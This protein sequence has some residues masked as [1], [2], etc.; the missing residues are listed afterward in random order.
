MDQDRNEGMNAG[1]GTSEDTSRAEEHARSA[2]ENRDALEAQH[3]RTEATT[4]DE[5]ERPVQGLIGDGG[6]PRMDWTEPGARTPIDGGMH[7]VGDAGALEDA[8]SAQANVA[9]VERNR[10]ALE[11][12][13]RRVEGTT[14]P[15]THGR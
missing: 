2:E 15:E 9:E 14:P 13:H 12:H 6:T 4:S 11:A 8:S 1:S 5:T 10:D 7:A 3:R